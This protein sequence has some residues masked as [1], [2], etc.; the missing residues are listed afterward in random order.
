MTRTSDQRREPISFTYLLKRLQQA[1]RT[2]AEEGL[3]EVGV[4]LPQLGVLRTLLGKPGASN[5]EL[6][7]FAFV[8]PQSMAE[9]LAT[10]EAAGLITRSADAKN[11]R[12]L[13]RTLTAEGARVA[14]RG[15]EEVARA[16]S[17]MIAGLSAT[18]QKQLRAL[19]ERCTA[20][21]A[22]PEAKD[23]ADG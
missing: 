8:S 7:R 10:L 2:E 20:A 4:T 16:E 23:G 3:R 11:A 14:Q 1:L 15:L 21:L 9:L 5:A 12:V 22:V 19:L 13:R 6:A 17:R 18:D